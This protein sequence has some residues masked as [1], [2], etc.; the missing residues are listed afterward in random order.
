LLPIAMGP[1]L[2][3]VVSKIDIPEAPIDERYGGAA[4]VG[5]QLGQNLALE[6]VAAAGVVG[7]VGSRGLKSGAEVVEYVGPNPVVSNQPWA[8]YQV[9][10]T[11]S[12]YEQVFKFTRNGKVRTFSADAARN[13]FLVE[14]KQGY[15][16]F[17]QNPLTW[18]SRMRDQATRYLK[19]VDTFGYRGVRYAVS[20]ADK[21]GALQKLFKQW[22]PEAVKS[23]KLRVYWVP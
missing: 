17:W 20:D 19:V 23:G 9:R 6:G 11:G 5:K 8:R 3:P 16:G 18:H 15:M 21:A 22:F 13:R 12:R 4:I 10:A 7:R 2:G 14:A 1:V